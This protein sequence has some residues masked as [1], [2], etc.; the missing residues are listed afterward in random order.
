M[1]PAHIHFLIYKEGYKT[2]ISQVYVNDDPNL[3]TYVQFGVTE[4]LVGNYVLHEDEKGQWY[5]L[6]QTF[7]MD[8]G[9]AMLPRA[10]ITGKAEGDRPVLTV[11]ERK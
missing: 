10:P 3:E 7:V 11:L 6:E 2:L 4:A 5:T 8:T 1:R 9:E